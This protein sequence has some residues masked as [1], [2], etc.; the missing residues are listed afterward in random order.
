MT[1]L[2]TASLPSSPLSVMVLMDDLSLPEK[3]VRGTH[4]IKPLDGTNYG[5]W[6]KSMR[7]LLM[8]V[9]VLDI[10]DSDK[11]RDADGQW[12]RCDRWVFTEIYFSCGPDQQQ[13]LSDTMTA[14]EA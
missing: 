9:G 2:K 8:G 7:I 14:K 6:K 5:N 1:T 12:L 13:S 10:I 11:P 4:T 3:I